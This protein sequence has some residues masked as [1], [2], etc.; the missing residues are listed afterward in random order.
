MRVRADS[1]LRAPLLRR[2]VMK[3]GAAL[4]SDAAT[5]ELRKGEAVRLEKNSHLFSHRGK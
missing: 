5:E 1:G 2:P 3:E 4:G